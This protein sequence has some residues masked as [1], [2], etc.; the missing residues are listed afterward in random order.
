MPRGAKRLSYQ[1]NPGAYLPAAQIRLWD[2]KKW[3]RFVE[4]ACRVMPTS[5]S[6]ATPVYVKVKRLGGKGDKGRDIEALLKKPRCIDG[7]DLYQCKHYK[8]PLTRGNLYPELAKFFGHM[9][10]G[11]YPAPAHYFICA[12]LDCGNELHDLLADSDKFQ[13]DFLDAWN[14]GQFGLETPSQLEIDT[15]KSFGFE[16]IQEVLATDLIDYHALDLPNHFKLFGITPVRPEDAPV[17]A[18]IGSNE[19]RY[20][21][22]LLDVYAEDAG[23]SWTCDTLTG[24]RYEEHFQSSRAE[25]FCAEGLSRFSRDLYAEID[26]SKDPFKLLL[27]QVHKG[28]RSTLTSPRH[29]SGLDR[30]DAVVT[31]AAGLQAN[32]NPLHPFLRAGDLQGTCHHLANEGNVT[33]VR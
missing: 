6:D 33:W 20:V 9:A 32:D 15:A 7:W 30:L 28:V 23:S 14:T 16:R 1:I 11:S 24:S 13:K 5:G 3:E 22:A 18:A 4:S 2:D 8:N 29:R 31:L 27:T 10:S 25:F 12:P 19:Q 17:P 26:P 21:Q